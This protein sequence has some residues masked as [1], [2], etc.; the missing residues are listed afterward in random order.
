MQQTMAVTNAQVL[1]AVR[2][3]AAIVV[4]EVNAAGP[5]GI[6][7][8][9]VYAALMTTGMSLADYQ[10]LIGALEKAGQISVH[11]QTLRAGHL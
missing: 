3:I 8:G 4:D 1:E 6:P 10:S 7:S 11:G 2:A 5:M 9:H